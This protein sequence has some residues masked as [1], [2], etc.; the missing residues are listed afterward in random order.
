MSP[1]IVLMCGT[2]VAC[3]DAVEPQS[4][5][6]IF[7]PAS[8]P[9]KSIFGDSIANGVGNETESEAEKHVNATDG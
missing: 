7:A 5:T 6:N 4:P 9:A 8:T 3:A 2:A 1:V